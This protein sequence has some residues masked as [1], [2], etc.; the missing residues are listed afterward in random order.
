MTGCIAFIIIFFIVIWL[1]AMLGSLPL[2]LLFAVVFLI[3]VIASKSYENKTKGVSELGTEDDLLEK[4]NEAAKQDRKKIYERELAEYNKD[5]ERA[6]LSGLPIPERN[7]TFE[8]NGDDWVR[9]DKRGTKDIKLIGCPICGR[10]LS[11]AAEI[12][13]GCG[14]PMKKNIEAVQ[15]EE[16]KTEGKP[17]CPTCGSTNV[18]KIPGTYKAAS[19]MA[20]GLFSVGT[21]TKTFKCNKCGYRW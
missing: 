9:T 19:A 6:K 17:T 14:H 15:S 12:C 13:P 2:G 20:W 18:T 5:V 7:L 3:A 16:K 4:A 1:G 8:F 21:L 10:G 11:P